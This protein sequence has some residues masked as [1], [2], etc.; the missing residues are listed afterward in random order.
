M[1]GLE[2]LETV[3]GFIHQTWN[4]TA[5][6]CYLYCHGSPCDLSRYL[7]SSCD[8]MGC[9]PSQVVMCK[10]GYR[11]GRWHVWPRQLNVWIM[12]NSL[13]GS[14]SH[15]PESNLPTAKPTHHMAVA[16]AFKAQVGRSNP[17]TGQ[18]PGE[19]FHLL[20][21]TLFVISIWATDSCQSSKTCS[22]S[23]KSQGIQK[24]D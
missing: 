2:P 4:I 6:C 14:P 12:T 16:S 22:A 1:P 8:S 9:F 5:L 19:T 7:F 3:L 18:C 10:G 13:M 20:P 17:G 11:W 15:C 23:G 21:V 24:R